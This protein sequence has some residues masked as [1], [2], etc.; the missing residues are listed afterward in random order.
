MNNPLNAL[1]VVIKGGGDMATGVAHRLHRAGMRLVITE[2][3]QPLVIRRTV[4]FASAIFRD[5]V[6]VEGIR[7][8][9]VE[10]S[11]IEEMW[12]EGSIPVLIDPEARIVDSLQPQVLV[13]AIMAKRNAGTRMHDAPLVIA[14]GP[15]FTVGMDC[16]A[17]VETNRGHYLGRVILAGSAEPNTGMPGTVDGYTEE[18]VLRVP[19][20]GLFQAHY[21][22]GE[23]V[24]AS[25]T[26]AH[27]NGFPVH[28]QIGG[29]LRGLLADGV[30]TTAGMKVGDIDPRGRVEH[31]FTISDKARAIGG[32]VLEA[33]LWLQTH[34]ITSPIPAGTRKLASPLV[35]APPTLPASP[36]PAFS[37]P[38]HGSRPDTA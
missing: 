26:V 13:D 15:G 30:P 35:T 14:L 22:I 21:R 24:R 31:C 28:A 23:H 36:R 37:I 9:L 3:P 27:V 16:H 33:I 2:L 29:V 4:A 6:E 11:R 5:E 7:A 12:W 32:G 20:A 8:R 25:Q 34:F 18:R 10:P 38:H 17:V 19:C 1:T